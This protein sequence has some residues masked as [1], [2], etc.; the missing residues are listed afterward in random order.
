MIK[1]PPCSG[2]KSTMVN[3]QECTNDLCQYSAS[4]DG[5]KAAEVRVKIA[6]AVANSKK[7][8]Q[9]GNHFITT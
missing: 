9:G 8:Y 6:E 4:F 1:A 5:L 2:C 3:K 7:V